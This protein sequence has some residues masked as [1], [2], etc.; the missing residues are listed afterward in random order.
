MGHTLSIGQIAKPP[1]RRSQEGRVEAAMADKGDRYPTVVVERGGEVVGWAGAGP[2]RN[3]SAYEG[4]ADHSVYV[5]RQAQ[6]SGGRPR[7][8]RRTLP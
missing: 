8:P 3:R 7:S 4:V 2:Y 1:S 5:A 6:G